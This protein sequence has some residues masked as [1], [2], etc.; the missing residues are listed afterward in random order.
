MVLLKAASS[1]ANEI[2]ARFERGDAAEGLVNRLIAESNVIERYVAR[3]GDGLPVD[4]RK[5]LER[6]ASAVQNAVNCGNGWLKSAAGPELAAQ[7]QRQRL[8]Q[9]YGL[10]I[11]YN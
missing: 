11:P 4:C 7:A 8:C 2:V 3:L 1:L 10:Q 9:A 5:E 6:L